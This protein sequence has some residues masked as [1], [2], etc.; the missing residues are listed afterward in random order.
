[1]FNHDF[2]LPKALKPEKQQ[3]SSC[4]TLYYPLPPCKCN[5]LFEWPP[6]TMIL[7]RDDYGLLTTLTCSCDVCK[8]WV[9]TDAFVFGGKESFRLT[10]DG[11]EAVLPWVKLSGAVVHIP[12]TKIQ[13]TIGFSFS[14]SHFLWS[15]NFIK[16]ALSS[17]IFYEIFLKYVSYVI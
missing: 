13:H 10:P 6:Y 14:I 4:D 16:L 15:T 9:V 2:L 3:I 11:Q 1:M 8:D 7:A 17:F 12:K 5:V